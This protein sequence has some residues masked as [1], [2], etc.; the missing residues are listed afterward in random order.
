VLNATRLLENIKN[1]SK[2]AG[3]DT[4][5]K[6]LGVHPGLATGDAGVANAVKELVTACTERACGDTP[7]P[8]I[9][10]SIAFMGLKG[11]PE[12]WT[13]LAG[14]VNP[15]DDTWNI[16]PIAR[17]QGA[18]SQDVDF[19]NPGR[20]PIV[21]REDGNLQRGTPLPTSVTPLIEGLV[22]T[23]TRAAAFEVENAQ[24]T[25]FFKASCT[26]CHESSTQINTG[27]IGGF[28]RG[29]GTLDAQGAEE[30]KARMPVPGGITGYVARA[31]SQIFTYNTRN[32]GY[33][34]SRPAI[35]GRTVAETV[36]I[37]DFLNTKVKPTPTSATDPTLLHGPGPDCSGTD[38]NGVSVD[39]KVFLCMRDNKADCFSVCKPAPAPEPTPAP[40]N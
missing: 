13:F 34:S 14:Q 30:L 28:L 19:I 6:A 15:A 29:D 12:P 39:V 36:E 5:G 10:R 17:L 23:A 21:P 16:L 8:P 31:D 22:T 18:V 38:A 3:A 26:S 40:A 4:S 24:S 35:S 7:Q 11:N 20:G 27:G 33:F 25:H 9:G 32:F 1:E 37:V 2:R